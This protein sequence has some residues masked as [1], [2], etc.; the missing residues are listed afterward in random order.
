MKTQQETQHQTTDT[1][2]EPPAVT[3]AG[4]FGDITR[5]KVFAGTSDDATDAARFY[6]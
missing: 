6:A 2:Y 4:E 5:G 3:D 1:G